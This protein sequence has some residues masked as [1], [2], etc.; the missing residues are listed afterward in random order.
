[1]TWVKINDGYHREDWQ[2]C[3]SDAAIRVWLQST[4]WCADRPEPSTF[5]T[6][7]QARS[8]VLGLGKKL[9]VIAELISPQIGAWEEVEGGYA[10][11][12]FE[13][14][15]PKS[16]ADRVRRYRET[17]RN[18][19]GPDDSPPGNAPSN[20][21]VTRYTGVTRGDVTPPATRTET[22]GNALAR[23]SYIQEPIT[24]VP[25]TSELSPPTPSVGED[26]IWEDFDEFIAVLEGTTGRRFRPDSEDRR[27]YHE[28]R[29]AGYSADDLRALARGIGRSP[30]HMGDNPQKMPQNSPRVVLRSSLRDTLISRGR[31][32]QLPR[33]PRRPSLAD[34]ADA[35]EDPGGAPPGLGVLRLAGGGQG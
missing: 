33:P 22:P 9:D 11:Q 7:A 5:M 28:Q 14:A 24:R 12:H 35:L 25:P 34:L 13:I 17:H 32:E 30:F 18:G 10:V 4:S 16:S 3:A 21:G 29:Q 19:A 15:T 26:V 20:A 1:V 23:G 27:A 2:L 31:G 6:I 8:I